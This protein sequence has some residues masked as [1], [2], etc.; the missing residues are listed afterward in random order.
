MVIERRKIKKYDVLIQKKNIKNIHLYITPPNGE[1]KLSVPINTKNET[2]DLF[3]SSKKY[4]IDKTLNTMKNTNW[5][6]NREYI[7]GE[8]LYYLGK[9]CRIKLHEHKDRYVSIDG[10]V[11]NIYVHNID[12]LNEKKKLIS[13]WQISTLEEIV[14][15][16]IEKY[17][18]I[19]KVKVCKYIIRKIKSHWGSCNET[20][21]ILTFNKE[22][23]GKPLSCIEYVVLHEMA[24]LL[25]HNHNSKFDDILDKNIK[26][27]RSIRNELNSLP[28][29]LI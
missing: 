27:W 14:E 6:D 24:H 8:S 17:E 5:L 7:N 3:V 20:D 18:K 4:E 25:I 11:A 29:Q 12:N 13:D 28:M 19:L 1:I 9:N 26:N 23:V 21:K 2:I 16:Y 22:L 10:K 15:K